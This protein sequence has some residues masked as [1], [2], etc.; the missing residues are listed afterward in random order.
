ML[1]EDTAMTTSPRHSVH[2]GRIAPIAFLALLLVSCI[3]NAGSIFLTGHDSDWHAYSGG[4]A[5]GAQNMNRVAIGYILDPTVNP[6]YASGVHMF[7]FVESN[8]TSWPADAHPGKWGIVSSGYV[9]GVDFEHH[10]A[11]TLDSELNLLGTKYSGVVVA[12]D[13]G[14]LLTQGEL[15]ILNARRADIIAFVNAGG[16]LFAMS[17]S[18]YTGLTSSGQFAFVPT[19][20]SSALFNES[21]SGYTVT[22]FGASLGLTDADVNGNVSH[23]IFLT[24]PTGMDVVDYDPNSQIVSVAGRSTNFVAVEPSTWGRV[25]ALYGR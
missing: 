11:S 4:N 20:V 18:G 6:Y 12:S 21:E 19:A 13:Y 10:D 3:A 22:S 17:E 2:L 25:K 1:R 14:G 7:L 16:G 9:E 15:N 23:S 5:V 24:V 8:I